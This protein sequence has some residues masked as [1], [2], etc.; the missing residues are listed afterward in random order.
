MSNSVSAWLLNVGAA[1]PIA[2]GQHELLEVMDEIKIHDL[3][4]GPNIC[5][6]VVKWRQHLLPLLDLSRLDDETTTP[7]KSSE[8]AAMFAWQS[9]PGEPLQYAA[10]L[11]HDMPLS[12]SVNDDQSVPVPEDMAPAWQTV[13]LA[14][15]EHEGATVILPSVDVL[16]TANDE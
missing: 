8:R 5:H 7:A 11:V 9:A 2:L 1:Y 6:Q 16:L 12:I 4:C 15:I 14:C 3:P 10:I 13:T